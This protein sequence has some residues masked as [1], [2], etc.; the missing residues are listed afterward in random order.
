[1][2][3]VFVP[4]RLKSKRLK[5]KALKKISNTE[6]IKW[7]LNCS[8]QIKKIKRVFLLT[9]FLKKDDGL[10]KIKYKKGIKVFR[11]DPTDL[12]KR[13]LDA[14]RKYKVKT[15]IRVTGDCPFISK[16]IMN[17]LLKSHLKKKADYTAAKKIC[18][19]NI[20]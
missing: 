5:L 15:I 12:F 8:S 7:C 13:F 4:V 10:T 1:M 9:S 11:G 16:E 17:Y 2:I 3:A 19:R 14:A 18:G 6:S 20:R